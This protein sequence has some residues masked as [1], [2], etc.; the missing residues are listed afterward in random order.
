MGV[1]I[2]APPTLGGALHFNFAMT[3]AAVAYNNSNHLKNVEMI[4]RLYL[5]VKEYDI[6]DTYI[7]RYIFPKHGVHISYRTL[8]YYK[9]A[10]MRHTLPETAQLNLFAA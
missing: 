8:M 9:R 6:P 4:I 2:K 5:R 7:I 10:K 3:V 1:T